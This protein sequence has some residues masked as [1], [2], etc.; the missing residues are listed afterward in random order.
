MFGAPIDKKIDVFFSLC[1][2]ILFIKYGAHAVKWF[3]DQSYPSQKILPAGRLMLASSWLTIINGVIFFVD[4]ILTT[5]N[6][7]P[8]NV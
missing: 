6:F 3:D 1:G 5:F 2:C 4:A 8:T 7:F